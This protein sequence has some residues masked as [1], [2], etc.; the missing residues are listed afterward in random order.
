MKDTP[1]VS[2]IVT[3]YNIESYVKQAIDSVKNQTHTNIEVIIVDDASTDK[4]ST[5]VADLISGDDR[6][7]LYTLPSNTPGGAGPPSNIGID[8]ANGQYIMFLD[9]DDYIVPDSIETMVFCALEKKA[10][11]VFCNYKN[12]ETGTNRIISPPDA[13]RWGSAKKAERIGDFNKLKKTLI[14]F[15]TVP[16][17]KLYKHT[18]IK[19]NNLRFP[20][21]DFFYEDNPLHWKSTILAKS[22]GLV[23]QDLFFHRVNRPGQT[24]VGSEQSLFKMFTHHQ[25]IFDELKLLG[26]KNEYGG[27][28]LCW[29]TSQL[30][31]ISRRSSDEMLDEL[32]EIANSCLSRHSPKDWTSAIQ[33]NAYSRG[34]FCMWKAVSN[35]DIE[36]FKR[37][38]HGDDIPKS[39]SYYQAYFICRDG[40]YKC[41]KQLASRNGRPI[42]NKFSRIDSLERKL[43]SIEKSLDDLKKAS[44]LQQKSMQALFIH[45]EDSNK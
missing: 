8:K 10:D 40:I 41:L 7:S 45:L 27:L 2:V 4:T 25:T 28:L 15:N 16:W 17:R 3:C 21:G 30:M 38:V 23:D 31:W 39:F 18:F 26:M 32:M 13:N 35:R 42:K 44:R 9:G 43:D 11:I 19:S 37:W 29:L 34:V 1:L 6:F 12:V 24:T 5:I 14:D 20:E 22:F 36:T 33:I